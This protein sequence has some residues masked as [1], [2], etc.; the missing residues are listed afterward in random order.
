MRSSELQWDSPINGTAVYNNELQSL[1]FFLLLAVWIWVNHLAATC[2]SFPLH[3]M[4]IKNSVYLLVV[5]FGL[6][7]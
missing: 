7:E 6:D 1:E 5:V 3:K 4:D 2:L